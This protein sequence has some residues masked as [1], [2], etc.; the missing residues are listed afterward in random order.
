MQTNKLL[1]IKNILT[2]L[3]TIVIILLLIYLGI[4]LYDSIKEAIDIRSLLP[5]EEKFDSYGLGKYFIIAIVQAILLIIAVVPTQLIQVIAGFCCG[6]KFGFLCC[7]VGIF[8]GN[9]I[10]F[11]IFRLMGNKVTQAL[12][13]KDQEK[14]EKVSNKENSKSMLFIL[15][16]YFIPGIPYGVA[17]IAAANSKINFFKYI[18]LTTLGAVPATVLCTIF[19][20]FAIEEA[21]IAFTI[22]LSVFC[23]GVILVLKFKNQLINHFENRSIVATLIWL[24][25]AFINAGFSIYYAII[26]D[27][28]KMFI[29]ILFFFAFILLYIIFNKPVSKIFEKSKQKYNMNYFQGPIK[30]ANSLLYSVLL[31]FLKLYFFTKYNVKVNKKD[32]PKIEHPS[33]LLF[34]HPAKLDFLWSFIPVYPN[35]VNPVVAYYYFCNFYVG[36]LLKNLGAFPKYLYQPDVSAMKN[37]VRVMK[38]NGILGIAPEGRLCPHGC[39][40]KII[41]STAKMI[42]KFGVQVIIT[43]IHG[44]YFST[45]KWAFT[46]RKGKIT[47]EFKEILTPEQIKNLS[48][49]EIY[50]ILKQECDYDE[51]KWQEENHIPFKGKRFAEGLEEILYICPV[52]HK[53]YTY[54]SKENILKCSHCHTEVTL[55]KYYQFHSD[56]KLIFKNIR[57]W[58]NFQKEVE[59]KNIDDPNYEL[60]SHV[61]LKH[62][63]PDGKGF[64]IVGEGFTTLTSK[65]ILYTGTINNEEKEILFKI[66]NL[67]AVPFGVREDFE[68]YH[69]NTLY[70]FVPDNIREC[71]KWSIVSEQMYQKY[72]DDNNLEELE[73]NE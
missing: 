55:D 11:V 3:F 14:L 72:L 8:I 4:D 30:R 29:N 38:N 26:N 24:L 17:S 23:I 1:K 22:L 57:D 35:K 47:V 27:I 69:H 39:M 60:T 34:N 10:I 45:P 18:L 53:E 66:E 65:G 25:I 43:K 62:P 6:A 20:H 37:I 41:P 71:V 67:P 5:V 32:M 44:S 56:N 50:D 42:K 54:S 70:Y 64:K 12:D 7:I 9:L 2:V 48:V 68:I 49:K 73:I 59:R 46:S 52:C 16:L 51:F 31:F 33:I 61:T 36:R 15:S 28:R 21:Y 19:G 58:Y 40:E 13:E 63:D